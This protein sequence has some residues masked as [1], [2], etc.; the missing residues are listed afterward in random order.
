MLVGWHRRRGFESLWQAGTDQAVIATQMVVERQLAETKQPSRAE[1]GREKF[2]EKVWA[3]KEG[4]GE[5][6]VNQL[7]RLGASCDWDRTAF[8]MAGAL[9]DTRTGHENS[10]NFHDS[11]IKVFVAMYNNGLIYRGKR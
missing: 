10:P 7:K 4:S 1:L 6:I 3:W 9:G 2:L 5:T 8:T 11:V